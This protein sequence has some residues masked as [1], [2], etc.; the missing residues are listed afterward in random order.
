MEIYFSYTKTRREFGRHCAFHDEAGEARSWGAMRA[1]RPA[2]RA[3]Q[4]SRA[5]RV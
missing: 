2:A 3:A 4:L 1:R 5:P